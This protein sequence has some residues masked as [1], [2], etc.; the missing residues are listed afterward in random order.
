MYK[1]LLILKY[2]RRKLAPMF[3]ALAVTLCTAMVIIVIS[4]MG[5]FL[6]LL[7]DSAQRLTGD[8]IVT[9]GTLTGFPHYDEMIEKL[10]ALP[11]VA[12]ATPV[13]RGFGLVQL[14]GRTIPVQ[15]EG[16]RPRELD[17]VVAYRGALY[18]GLPEDEGVD[19]RE[20]AMELRTPEPWVEGADGSADR[21][22][23]ERAMVIGIE[24]NPRHVR[25]EQGRY[26]ELNSAVGTV[27]TLTVAPVTQQGGLLE[28]SVRPLAVVNEFKSGLYEVDANRVYVPF[29]L[30][31]AMLRT[32]GL[33]AA[34]RLDV[35]ALAAR[36][37]GP[38]PPL[39]LPA[40]RSPPGVRSRDRPA[41]I[42]CC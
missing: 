14:E 12:T 30:L 18:W 37:G 11:E 9:A 34:R 28:P 4:V 10:E 27:V 19:L 2:L 41:R 39:A 8:V 35:C 36:G 16:V 38:D 26:R 25:D 20:A 13:V 5:G 29:E 7:R 32:S 23:P 1:L 15:V 24:V 22:A 33:R 40:R 3:A 31:Q 6:D 17:R 21:G 42:R